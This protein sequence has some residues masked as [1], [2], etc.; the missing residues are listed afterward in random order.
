MIKSFSCNLLSAVKGI[1]LAN[2]SNMLQKDGLSHD[3]AKIPVV[4][5]DFQRKIRYGTI[6]IPHKLIMNKPNPTLQEIFQEIRIF[7]SLEKEKR[8]KLC[9]RL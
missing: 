4:K 8:S 5:L 3:S 2:D 6:F 7:V 9:A 1:V